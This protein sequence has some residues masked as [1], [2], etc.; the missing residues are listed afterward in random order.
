LPLKLTRSSLAS[1][2]TGIP[3]TEIP[4]TLQDAMTITYKLGLRYLWVDALTII[5]DDEDD[6]YAEATKMA[7]VYGNAHVTIAA[8]YSQDFNAGIFA[9]RDSLLRYYRVW[10]LPKPLTTKPSP[11]EE[12]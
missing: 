6:W 11:V 12:L 10:P 2:M 1:F 5:Q 3:W 4:K 8:T 7:I 9:P